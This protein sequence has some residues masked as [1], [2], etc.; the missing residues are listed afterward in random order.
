M[1]LDYVIW[2]PAFVH[3]FIKCLGMVP[4]GSLLWACDDELFFST[5]ILAE[6]WLNVVY[7]LNITLSRGPSN[8]KIPWTYFLIYLGV[9]FVNRIRG[10]WRIMS[11]PRRNNCLAPKFKMRCGKRYRNRTLMSIHSLYVSLHSNIKKLDSECGTRTCRYQSTMFQKMHN[12]FVFLL[13]AWVG[14]VLR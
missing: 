4:A 14:P 12:W 11:R 7:K 8:K 10:I 2:I 6:W 5:V 1:W 3:L 9:L 13:M